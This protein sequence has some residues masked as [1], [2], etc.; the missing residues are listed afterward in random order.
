MKWLRGR[1][2]T[3]SPGYEPSVGTFYYPALVILLLLAGCA[4]PETAPPVVREAVPEEPCKAKLGPRP[5]YPADTLTGDEDIW[6]M[7]TTLWADRKARRARELELETVVE[8]C[9]RPI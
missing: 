8:G 9:T 5:A 1:N 4:T 7:G 3:A 6:Q 2:L